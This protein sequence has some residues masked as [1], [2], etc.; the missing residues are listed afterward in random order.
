MGDKSTIS[1]TTILHNKSWKQGLSDLIHP[2]CLSHS[3][4]ECLFCPGVLWPI[5]QGGEQQLIRSR[6]A[7]VRRI[8]DGLSFSVSGRVP[9]TAQFSFQSSST[10]SLLHSWSM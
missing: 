9:S 2:R 1:S 8:D 10:R 7:P 5:N 6:I 3:H 4:V